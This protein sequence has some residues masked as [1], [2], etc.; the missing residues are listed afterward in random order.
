[1]GSVN[2]VILIGNLGADPEIRSTQDGREIAS[3]SIATSEKWKDKKTGEQ[4]VKTEWHKI[5]VFNEGI[6]NIVKQYVKKGQSVWIEGKVRTR[7]YAD[8]AGKNSYSTEVVLDGFNASL[9]I[10]N[11]G[12]NESK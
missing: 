3:F 7:K 11:K 2:K 5:V 12:E 1:M 9:V 4:K 8:K 6:V 10:L